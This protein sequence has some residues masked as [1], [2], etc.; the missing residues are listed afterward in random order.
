[1]KRGRTHTHGDTAW[2]ARPTASLLLAWKYNA[3]TAIN[4][5]KVPYAGITTHYSGEYAEGAVR[6][7]KTNRHEE[8]RNINN[9]SE[10]NDRKRNN[11]H[12]HS[13]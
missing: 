9:D 10:E 2:I 6:K 13:S 11:L 5:W 12:E 3:I 1:M 8:K 4:A 7:D